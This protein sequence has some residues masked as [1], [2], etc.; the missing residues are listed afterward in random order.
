MTYQANSGK[1]ADGSVPLGLQASSK[2][3][4]YPHDWSNRST[5]PMCKNKG[6]IPDCSTYRPIRLMSH[7]LMIFERVLEI[8]KLVIQSVRVKGAGTADTTHT[9]HIMMEHKEE[10]S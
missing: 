3:R 8:R 7:I 4:A 10:R 9:V 5:I 1:N 2:Q 6:N